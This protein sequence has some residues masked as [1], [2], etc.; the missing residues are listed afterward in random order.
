[1]VFK[2]RLDAQAIAAAKRLKFLAVAAS[3]AVEQLT[4][5]SSRLTSA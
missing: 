4:A 5:F 1:M 2:V 3:L